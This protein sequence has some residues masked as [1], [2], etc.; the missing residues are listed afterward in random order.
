M[1]MAIT[2]SEH[3][4]LNTGIMNESVLGQSRQVSKEIRTEGSTVVVRKSTEIIEAELRL[5]G[6]PRP[7]ELST[8]GGLPTLGGICK[9]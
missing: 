9:C 7:G 6:L 8:L 2:V 1:G 4:G 3:A 5:G